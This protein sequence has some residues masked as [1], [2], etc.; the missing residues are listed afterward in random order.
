MHI[1]SGMEEGASKA[2]DRLE[3]IARS[4]MVASRGGYVGSAGPCEMREPSQH[5]G[6]QGRRAQAC[7]DIAMTTTT[8]DTLA[9][10]AAPVASAVLASAMEIGKRETWNQLDVL[11]AAIAE[12][13]Q[14]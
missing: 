12:G 4:L 7:S 11:V 6:S 13:R 10:S 5:G 3:E 9:S 2:F 1:A 14:Q 8:N